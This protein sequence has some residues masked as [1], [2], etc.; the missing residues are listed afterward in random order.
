MEAD[1]LL[2]PTYA[3]AR[4]AQIRGIPPLIQRATLANSVRRILKAGF[5]A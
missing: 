1:K 4:I 5:P 3:A 2:N